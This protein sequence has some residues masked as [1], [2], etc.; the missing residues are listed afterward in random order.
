MSHPS[1]RFHIR[2]P[3]LFFSEECSALPN[4]LSFGLKTVNSLPVDHGTLVEVECIPGY[5]LSGSRLITCIRQNNWQ[6]ETTPDCILGTLLTYIQITNT[7]SCWE[8]WISDDRISILSLLILFDT[9]S[10]IYWNKNFTYFLSIITVQLEYEN[11]SWR[12]NP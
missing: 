9:W 6:Y 12:S 11:L 4:A 8:H 7:F 2:D 10:S 3:V 5:S 1:T